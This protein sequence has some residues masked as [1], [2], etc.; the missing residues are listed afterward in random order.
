MNGRSSFWHDS[1]RCVHLLIPGVARIVSL[2]LGSLNQAIR[3]LAAA[4]G[5]PCLLS[6]HSCERIAWTVVI[7]VPSTGD[8]V[9]NLSFW[10]CDPVDQLAPTLY[11]WLW[12][13]RDG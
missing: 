13:N 2:A 5:L 10:R 9:R 4:D 8:R 6:F 7:T 11:R 12:I 1:V 3:A